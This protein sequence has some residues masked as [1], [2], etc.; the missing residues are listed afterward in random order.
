MKFP[1]EI[2]VKAMGKNTPEFESHVV[3]L[4]R[5]HYPDLKESDVH[6]NPSKNGNYLAVTTKIIAS[7]RAHADRIY[8]TLT[9]DDLVVMAI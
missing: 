4:V 8:Q 9:D 7:D 3:A 6:S 2:S 1:C 5:S